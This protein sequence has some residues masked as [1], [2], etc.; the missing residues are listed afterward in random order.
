[1]KTNYWLVE[2]KHEVGIAVAIIVARVVADQL[3]MVAVLSS[4]SNSRMFFPIYDGGLIIT[5]VIHKT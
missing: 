2:R 3:A 4:I 5:S 1:M